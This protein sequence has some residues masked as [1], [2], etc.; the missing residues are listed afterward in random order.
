MIRLH[1]YIKAL[2]LCLLSGLSLLA[3]AQEIKTM[4]Q[5][6]HPW[7]PVSDLKTDGVIIY[8]TNNIEGLSFE[9]RVN[10]WKIHQYQLL[11]MTSLSWGPN[12]NHQFKAQLLSNGKVRRHGK[13]SYFI[14]TEEYCDYLFN[15]KI[16][17]AIDAGIN[18]IILEEPEFYR[19]C[20]PE[21]SD[22]KKNEI[23][24]QALQ[25]VVQL[26][27]NYGRQH[28]RNISCYIATHSILNYHNWNIISPEFLLDNIPDIDGL[29]GQVWQDTAES[30][31]DSS[32]DLFQHAYL[33]YASLLAVAHAS[34]RKIFFLTD[35]A[36][37]KARN[38]EDYRKGYLA[39]TLAMMMFPEV[40]SYEVLPWPHRIFETRYSANDRDTA[41][42]MIPSDYAA[43]ILLVNQILKDLPQDSTP[44]RSSCF[45]INNDFLTT[46]ELSNN[47]P[48]ITQCFKK[49]I[50]I[51]FSKNN[52]EKR[53]TSNMPFRCMDIQRGRYRF[54]YN[55]NQQTAKVNAGKHLFIDVT[56]PMLKVTK[57][58][59]LKKGEGDFLVVF[60]AQQSGKSKIL[61]SGSTDIIQT[62][63]KQTFE[64][65]SKGPTALENKMRILLAFRPNHINITDHKGQQVSF[66]KAFD[67][68][69][70]T[71]FLS[72]PNDHLGNHISISQ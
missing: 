21:I 17:R 8:D 48:E 64:Y 66:N 47:L 36:G 35:P 52:E 18:H 11:F 38:W 46:N 50:Y 33:E 24:V 9:Q 71:L 16:K 60:N 5:S 15:T 55:A 57:S 29:I 3:K 27:K 22:K 10:T 26:T 70:H 20:N 44:Q 31:H 56:D 28:N 69:S 40:N 7:R 41:K 59:T 4:F 61:L 51:R 67:P 25:R 45:L 72:F 1:P 54:I 14:P 13:D 19:N 34:Q 30:F 37:D 42:V 65:I 12:V 62:N 53:N 32:L 23:L 49:G 6:P 58:I 43:L 63:S 68:Y 2:I 39:T